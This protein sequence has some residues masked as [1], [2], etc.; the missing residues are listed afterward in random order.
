VTFVFSHPLPTLKGGIASLGS[1]QAVLLQ[2]FWNTFTFQSETR[3][4]KSDA[5]IQ[6]GIETAKKKQ[7]KLQRTLLFPLFSII[8]FILSFLHAQMQGT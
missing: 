8:H 3:L 4:Q 1:A 2:W 5:K 6:K 7:K